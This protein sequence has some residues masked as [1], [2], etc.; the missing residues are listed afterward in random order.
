MSCASSLSVQFCFYFK[1]AV[2]D[3]TLIHQEQVVFSDLYT[4]DPLRDWVY[5][6]GS[7]VHLRLQTMRV[8]NLPDNFGSAGLMDA[9]EKALGKREEFDKLPAEI[10]V[11]FDDGGQLIL[12]CFVSM[13]LS[14]DIM[15]LKEPIRL[16]DTDLVFVCDL[17][18]VCFV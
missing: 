1:Y 18:F 16:A 5:A 6:A 4:M 12:E 7:I 2:V 14:K 8:R 3:F 17:L 9:L 15:D 10:D 11:D 13:E